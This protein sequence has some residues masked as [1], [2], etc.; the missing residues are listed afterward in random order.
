MRKFLSFILLF[1][2]AV[3]VFAVPANRKP[4]VI[5]Q[6]DGTMLSVVLKGDESMR[7][8]TT[9]DGK[10]IV[11]EDNGD[12]CYATFSS[13]GRFVSTGVIAHDK[14][15]RNNVENELLSGMDYD[16]MKAAVSKTHKLRSAK[17]RGT[18]ATRAASSSIVPKGEVLV[19]VLLVQYKDVKFSY[20]KE[21]I[22]KLL[23]EEGYKYKFGVSNIESHGSA[24]DYFIAQSD[25]LFFPK[26]VVTD[27]LTL[28]N[29]MS[30]YGGNN[31]SGEDSRPQ[32]MIRDGIDLADN[33]GWDFSQFDNDKNGEVEFIFC[34]YA[35]Y[36]ESNQADANTIWPHKWELSSAIGKKKVDGVYCDTYACSSEL[37]MNEKY[38]EE[39][40][41]WL[42]GIGTICHEF[43]HCL[44]LADIYDVNGESGN[45]CMNEWD[46]MDYGIRKDFLVEENKKAH[47][48]VTTPQCRIK[49]A[50]CGANKL[51]GGKWNMN[52]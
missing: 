40:D 23:N 2:L 46:I 26:F 9:R 48:S 20:T 34:I 19:P 36:S 24:R 10:Y 49:C 43:S 35:G 28:P 50:A 33:A 21:H 16:A 51:N 25:S 31:S 29:E 8:Y 42:S 6:S 17:Y 14:E 4:F 12:F 22:N 32:E 47:M 11:K 39:Y 27:I 30:Y 7:F 52:N 1:V 37:N 44:G 3:S 45:F 13:E 18:A 15:K 38:E 41:K 5:K